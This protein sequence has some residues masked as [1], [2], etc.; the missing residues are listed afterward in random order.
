[1][2]K[3]AILFYTFFAA[4]TL[5]LFSASSNKTEYKVENVLVATYP[6]VIIPVAAEYINA[7][8]DKLN[9]E[10]FDLMILQ[11]DT[12]GGLDSSMRVII[13]RMLESKKPIVVYV[14]PKGARAASAGVFI[15]MA[16][17]IAVMSPSTNIG[18][19]HPVMLGGGG[20][21]DF[22]P[23][24]KDKKEKNKKL[25]SAME[26]KVLNDAKAYIKSITQYKKRNVDWAVNAVTKSDSITAEEALNKKVIEFIADDIND[27]L[28]KINNYELDEFGVLKTDNI[29]NIYHYELTARQKFLTTITDPNIAMLL[30]SIG[31]IGIFIE[32]YNPGLILPGVVGAISLVIGLYSFQTL[33]ANFA[34]ILLILLGLLFLL[35]EI[36][37]MSYGLLTFA[38]VI[39]IFL[40]STMLFKNASGVSGIGIDT[41]VL[42]MNMAGLV[43]VVLI[44]A[45]IVVKA[46]MKKVETG[47]EAMVGEKGRAETDLSPKG[48]V[49]VEGELW[50]AVSVE[51]NIEKGSEIEVIGLDG[52][53]L[54][55]KKI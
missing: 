28:K 3:K 37:V 7:A 1:M 8:I 5:S 15:T 21:L 16:S 31:A 14:A 33:S 52:F 47:A 18:A 53:K 25:S 29:K 51:G 43:I 45:Y 22:D 11:L 26:E 40:G 9:K 54:K 13:K 2:F 55:V 44:L 48:K 6:G 23:V 41:G 50:D 10:D 32:L 46:H 24:N 27:L 35:V 20:G 38:A 17:H 12:P 30:M 39:S 42:I 34:G 49:L 36:K 4:F 19:A